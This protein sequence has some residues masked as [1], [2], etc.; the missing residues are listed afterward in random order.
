VEQL[1]KDSEI[2]KN[3]IEKNVLVV[4][5]KV[6]SDLGVSAQ[7]DA[8]DIEGRLAKIEGTL[9]ALQKDKGGVARALLATVVG[10][11]LFLALMK[12]WL[13]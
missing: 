7:K 1:L 13:S 10:L 2:Q 8:E 3:E 11:W 9:D 12:P 6:V 4:V 5:Q